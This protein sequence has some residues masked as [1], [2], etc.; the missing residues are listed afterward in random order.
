M[1]TLSIVELNILEIVKRKGKISISNLAKSIDEDVSGL[2]SALNS[3]IEKGYINVNG[4][5]V[6][7]TLCGLK[8]LEGNSIKG[9]RVIVAVGENL[10]KCSL[11]KISENVYVAP[12]RQKLSKQLR[13][14]GAIV[15]EGYALYEM[16]ERKA[17]DWK[18]I[19]FGKAEKSLAIA[20]K[21]STTG[22]LKY[23]K[24]LMIS[25]LREMLKLEDLRSED[26]RFVRRMINRL[27]KR[28]S[29]LDIAEAYRLVKSL[30]KSSV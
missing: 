16:K 11:R 9:N 21:A 4:G 14:R 26:R 29:K 17:K 15:F 20:S 5:Y 10:D 23:A 25:A 22:Q 13:L 3:L 1:D 18:K 2:S 8:A 12:W 19:I 27:G 30:L 7:L 6:T 24:L 28:D